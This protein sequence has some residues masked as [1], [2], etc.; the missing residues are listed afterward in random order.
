M[1]ATHTDARIVKDFRRGCSVERI[2]RKIGRPDDVQRVREALQRAG[3]L[4][5]EPPTLQES[6]TSPHSDEAPFD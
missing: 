4:P 6:P 3:L 5:Q 1:A 2:A